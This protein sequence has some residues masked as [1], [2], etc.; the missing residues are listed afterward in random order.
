MLVEVRKKDVWWTQGA[1][2]EGSWLAA[3]SLIEQAALLSL[4]RCKVWLSVAGVPGQSNSGS[5]FI[6]LTKFTRDW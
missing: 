1:A 3:K 2:L 4:P 6:I 5:Y